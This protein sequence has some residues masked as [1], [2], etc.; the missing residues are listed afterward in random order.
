MKY[1]EPASQLE[2]TRAVPALLAVVAG[3]LLWAAFPTQNLPAA[4][5]VALVPLFFL[6]ELRGLGRPVLWA[7]LGGLVFFGLLTYWSHCFHPLAWPFL[8]LAC[9]LAWP[10]FMLGYK[11][12]RRRFIYW[13]LLLVP[14]LWVAI[15]QFRSVGY[16][17]FPWG[18]V[19]YTQWQQVSL[20]QLTTLTGIAGVSFLVVLVNYVVFRLLQCRL[21]DNRLL[22]LAFAVVVLMAAVLLL[23]HQ[24]IPD[25]TR[26]PRGNYRVAV[27]QPNFPP[28]MHWETEAAAY[29]RKLRTLTEQAAAH[30]PHLLIWA[31]T[32]VPIALQRDA[33]GRW[34]DPIAAKFWAQTIQRRFHLLVGRP[35]SI[36]GSNGALRDYNCAVLYDTD[37]VPVNYE[38]KE[39]L[40][41]F[42]ETLPFLHEIN[43]IEKFGASVG[44]SD[45][46]PVARKQP[47]TVPGGK[48]ALLVCYESTFGDLTRRQVA[49]G[50][51]LLVNITNDVWSLSEDAH[52]QH[53]AM[54]V[55]RAAETRTPL[56]R[57]GNSGVSAIVDAW[58]RPQLESP[59]MRDYVA[60]EDIT[61]RTEGP[62]FYVR[63][64]D[65][66][67]WSCFYGL[68]L[69]LVYQAVRQLWRLRLRARVFA[70]RR[71]RRRADD[72]EDDDDDDPAGLTIDSDDRDA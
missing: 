20:L 23:G 9:S 19:G 52:W 61:W 31:E 10:L 27:V 66:F 50:A 21:L 55:V 68:A 26:M 12:I 47:M 25:Q 28:V 3:A 49:A 38:G 17:G 36:T 29:L 54:S 11:I 35:V 41:P 70:R 2:T 6:G 62:T 71:A 69:L 18:V 60:I 39:H 46:V 33:A 15:E 63:R 34:R 13:S 40:V 24:A 22:L 67:A 64:G 72:E 59:V 42:G 4:A 37:G 53:Y 7:W 57:A 65:W 43:W 51:T 8:T 45:Y 16:W 56:V 30:R 48:L 14:A 32:A 1:G 58:A 5:W 44:I